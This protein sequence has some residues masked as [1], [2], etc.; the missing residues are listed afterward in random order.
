MVMGLKNDPLVRISYEATACESML[1][2][3][4]DKRLV[5]PSQNN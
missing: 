3:L 5:I 2:G 1:A 4:A